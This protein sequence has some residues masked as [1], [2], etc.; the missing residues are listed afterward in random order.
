MDRFVALS[1]L[2]NLIRTGNPQKMTQAVFLPSRFLRMDRGDLNCRYSSNIVKL[3]VGDTNV[4]AMTSV[5]FTRKCKVR[6][7]LWKSLATKNR[8][9]HAN[10]DCDESSSEGIVKLN[11][12]GTETWKSPRKLRWTVKVEQLKNENFGLDSIPHRNDQ[13]A[14]KIMKR[15]IEERGSMPWLQHGPRSISLLHTREDVCPRDSAAKNCVLVFL[16]SATIF[17]TN[18]SIM[19][20]NGSVEITDN[21]ANAQPLGKVRDAA[22]FLEKLA[23]GK[24][25][26]KILDKVMTVISGQTAVTPETIEGLKSTIDGEDYHDWKTDL[27]NDVA[28]FWSTT[29]DVV[30]NFNPLSWTESAS[31]GIQ[32]LVETAAERFAAFELST[33]V[34]LGERWLLWTPLVVIPMYIQ[35]S[36]LR[37]RDEGNSDSE[38]KEERKDAVE[39][40][41]EAIAKAVKVREELERIELKANLLDLV[42]SLEKGAWQSSK[43]DQEAKRRQIDETMDRLQELNPSQR[44]IVSSELGGTTARNTENDSIALINSPSDVDGDWSL[45]YVSRA[46]NQ[47]QQRELPQ[48]PSLDLFGI[49][50]NNMRQKVWRKRLRGSIQIIEDDLADEMMTKNTAEIRFGPLGVMEVSVQGSWENL[51]NGKGALVSFD[52]F[53]ARPI[54]LLGTPV[55]EDLPSIDVSI[56]RALQTSGEWE[57]VY[58]DNSIRIHR[59][60]TQQRYLFRKTT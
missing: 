36:R 45:I 30:S 22:I 20:V 15:K 18:P 39:L 56:P 27:A 12:P 40:S 35:M 58:M 28:N 16:I 60:R 42:Y 51:K 10:I 11:G 19:V 37:N 21:I 23:G 7:N 41:E 47:S 50:L 1:H 43:I 38:K 8:N 6:R 3:S 44:P 17:L 24:G 32:G 52:T 49:E 59:G 14:V 55:R 26:T 54:E 57:V 4:H 53:S 2:G 46:V 13:S 48:F 25:P 29:L 33:L 34:A 5:H 31:T 9:A